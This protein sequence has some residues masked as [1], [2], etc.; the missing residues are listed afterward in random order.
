[1]EKTLITKAVGYLV[2]QGLKLLA[3]KTD[4]G[5]DDRIIE[6]VEHVYKN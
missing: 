6:Y 3:K 4:N 5:I 1:M 2:F